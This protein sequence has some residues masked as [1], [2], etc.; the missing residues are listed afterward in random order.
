MI[1]RAFRYIDILTFQVWRLRISNIGGVMKS[2]C[3]YANVMISKI[4]IFNSRLLD[5]N[6]EHQALIPLVDH[7]EGYEW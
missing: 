5:P 3:V 2:M 6:Q 7:L 4:R 1:P